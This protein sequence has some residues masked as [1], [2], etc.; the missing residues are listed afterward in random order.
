MFHCACQAAFVLEEEG[1]HFTLLWLIYADLNF[2]GGM[3]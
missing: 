2:S 3:A 1:L